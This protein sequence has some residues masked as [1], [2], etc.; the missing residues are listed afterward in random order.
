MSPAIRLLCTFIDKSCFRPD[1]INMSIDEVLPSAIRHFCGRICDKSDFQALPDDDAA[2]F[3]PESARPSDAFAANQS[4]SRFR[5]TT[6]QG[7]RPNRP[8]SR[9]RRH[10]KRRPRHFFRKCVRLQGTAAGLW[11][12]GPKLPRVQDY[13]SQGH[14]CR[15]TVHMAT[16]AKQWFAGERLHD[17]GSQ[18]HGSQLRTYCPLFVRKGKL[19]F[20]KEN[21]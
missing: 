1:D 12:A 21:K 13:G 4:C 10:G 7:F 16:S 8:F 19:E 15:I 18:G 9:T 6:R 17:H 3:S 5:L 11:V 14:G 20:T 2:T